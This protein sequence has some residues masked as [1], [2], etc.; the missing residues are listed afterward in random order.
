MKNQP[1]PFVEIKGERE[2]RRKAAI[3]AVEKIL[4]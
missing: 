2:Q 1:V 4:K 3:D